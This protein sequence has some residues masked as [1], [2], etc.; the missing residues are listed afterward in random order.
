MWYEV[1]QLWCNTLDA[2]FLDFLQVFTQSL[3]L[4]SSPVIFYF[5]QESWYTIF[6]VNFKVKSCLLQY[7]PFLE[8]LV[9]L[10]FSDLCTLSSFMFTFQTKPFMPSTRKA[11][12][13]HSLTYW[14]P[15]PT[16]RIWSKPCLDSNIRTTRPVKFNLLFSENNA[17]K[18]K[19]K[20]KS[21][22]HIPVL[23]HRHHPYYYHYYQWHTDSAIK[24]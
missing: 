13:F 6:I 5:S 19:L 23:L 21:F 10:A 8:G 3:R 1:L 9:G 15:S 18:I 24:G 22:H 16:G 17:N 4:Q 2:C 7:H 14:R 12:N 20:S 11:H